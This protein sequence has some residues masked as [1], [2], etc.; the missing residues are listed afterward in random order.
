MSDPRII[1]S[2]ERA[3]ASHEETGGEVTG[4]ALVTFHGETGYMLSAANYQE[5]EEAQL[6]IDD[7]ADLLDFGDGPDTL[8]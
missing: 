6:V 2:L 8:Q 7:I 5:H 3:L 1:E 4:Y